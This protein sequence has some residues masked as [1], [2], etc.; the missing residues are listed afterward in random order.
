[1]DERKNTG[2]LRRNA[3]RE[4]ETQPSHRGSCEIHGVKF[5]ISAWVNEDRE[6]K[7]KY[8]RLAFEERKAE[9]E[10]GSGKAETG[11][12]NKEGEYVW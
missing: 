6:T 1:M 9:E 3:K 2:S 12:K 11:E 8:F 5:W 4:K 7:E 10:S